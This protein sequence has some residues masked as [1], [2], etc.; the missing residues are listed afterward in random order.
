MKTLLAF[1]VILPLL[2]SVFYTKSRGHNHKPE[3]AAVSYE[4][5]Y[6][7][8]M[9]Y[10]LTYY[11]VEKDS[12][13]QVRI[14]WLKNHGPDVLAIKGTEEV[15]ERIGALSAQYKLHRIKQSY[16]PSV[17]VLDGTSWHMYL[18]FQKGSISSGGNNASA[19]A[20]RMQG[21][22]SINDYL[23]SL[24]DA[25]TEADIILREDYRTFIGR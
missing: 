24:I 18:R 2:G 22:Y 13:G 17:Q 19:P 1:S 6:S 7:S 20:R 23:Q 11:K 4:Y 3:G 8:T 25:S 5:N 16:W 12:A 14:A 21:I 15:L 9:A 10:P